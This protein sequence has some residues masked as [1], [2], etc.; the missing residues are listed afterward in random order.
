MHVTLLLPGALLPRE[1][2]GALQEPLAQTTLAA[3]LARAELV[4]DTAADGPAHLAWLAEHLFHRP[5]PLATGP[6]AYAA[7]TGASSGTPLWHAD[8]VH[9]EL[10]RDHLFL[11]P[12]ADT[13]SDAEAAALLG[14]AN[15]LAASC[16]ASFLRADGH[17]FLKTARPW[18][19]QAAPLAAALGQPLHAVLPAGDDVQRWN[20]LLTEIQM[21][22][23]DHPVNAARESRGEATINSVWLHGGGRW[24]RLADTA[25]TAVQSDAP[26]WRGAA[27][28]ASLPMCGPG[29]TTPDGA[30]VVWTELLAPRLLQDWSQWL[31]TLQVI[32]HRLAALTRVAGVDLVL[33]G[34]G[35]VRR[36][37]ARAGDRLKF[38][39][40]RT[41]EQALAQ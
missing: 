3:V 22:W 37:M 40:S 26:E 39:R 35:I 13:P 41:L 6:Y 11:A 14:V 19:L 33:T 30:L 17:W 10:A 20:R 5:T 12:L 9:V 8:P 21:A 1:V 25:F 16:D 31:A 15:E 2:V 18:A 34:D 23:H 24:Q 36:L 38:W 28:A 29:C 27:W 4:G 32:D 7:L